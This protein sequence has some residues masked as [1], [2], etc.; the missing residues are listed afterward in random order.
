MGKRAYRLASV[1]EPADAAEA[2]RLFEQLS[3]EYDLCVEGLSEVR[4]IWGEG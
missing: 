2:R 1:L 4:K 3:E